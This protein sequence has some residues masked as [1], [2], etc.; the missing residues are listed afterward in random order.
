MSP[1]ELPNVSRL[2]RAQIA[3]SYDPVSGEA[4][5]LKIGRAALATRQ[6]VLDGQYWVQD[7]YFVVFP[8]WFIASLLGTALSSYGVARTGNASIAFIITVM[9]IYVVL[10]LC[11][12]VVAWWRSYNC[13]RAWSYLIIALTIFQ[14]AVFLAWI[15]GYTNILRAIP[16]LWWTM[17]AVQLVLSVVFIGA[18]LAF[19]SLFKGYL[20]GGSQVN[21]FRSLTN[22]AE[23]QAKYNPGML[24]GRAF[25]EMVHVAVH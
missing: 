3:V 24:I 21:T 2:D 7:I 13:L 10:S 19:N 6:A 16:W 8:V 18:T 5:S 4:S 15:F 23:L 17:F 1:K 14:L 25:I 9:I 11:S 12:V 22:A 20:V